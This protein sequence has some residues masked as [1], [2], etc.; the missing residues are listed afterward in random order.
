MLTA[1][2]IAKEYD[3]EI[4]L[5]HATD[6]QAILDQIKESGFPCICG[7]SLCHKDKFECANDSFETPNKMY[8]K[9]NLICDHN[10]FPIQS[11][12]ISAIKC[13]TCT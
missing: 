4:T 10:R 11:P 1:I 9:R 12:T 5:D 6:S 3:I 13:R 7:P 2:R 8:E